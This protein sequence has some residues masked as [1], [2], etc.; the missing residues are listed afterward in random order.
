MQ[1]IYIYLLK[2]SLK[3]IAITEINLVLICESYFL[4]NRIYNV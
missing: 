3:C 4:Y 1:E 2:L